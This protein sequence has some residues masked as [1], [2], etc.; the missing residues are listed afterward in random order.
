VSVENR[1]SASRQTS[2]S[3]NCLG[4]LKRIKILAKMNE[5][6]SMEMRSVRLLVCLA[7]LVLLI[8]PGVGCTSHDQGT[9][10][11]NWS[12]WN[13][14]R[15]KDL[16]TIN[17]SSVAQCLQ[18]INPPY[19]GDPADQPTKD[20]F[21]AIRDWVAANI[22]YKSDEEQWGV[23]DY[24]QTPDETLSLGSGDCEDF[25]ILLC[26]LLRAYGIGEE[27]IFVAIGVDDDGYGHAFL[28]ENWYLDGEWRALEPQAGA[29]TFPPG[30]RFKD[31]SLADF[32]LLRDYE[33]ILAFNDSYYYDESFPWDQS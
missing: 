21:D 17:S 10:G 14:D 29:Q 16:I 2:D 20:G 32:K 26:T 28:I 25:A 31:Y 12:S 5:G 4:V 19:E 1:K 11:D 27:Q 3:R 13:A 8:L 7:A 15:F 22:Q 24:W 6:L 23:D 30:P 33:I 18:D 9:T